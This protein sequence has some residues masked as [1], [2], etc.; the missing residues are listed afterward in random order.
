VARHVTLRGSDHGG[1][2]GIDQNLI[3]CAGAVGTPTLLLRSGIGAPDHLQ[4][5]QIPV[6]HELPG[7]GENL[8]DHPEA[9][10]YYEG[11]DGGRGLSFSTL[12]ANT[13]APFQ[14]LFARRG[15][16]TSNVVEAGGFACTDSSLAEPDVQFH[17]IPTKVRHDGAR[18]TWGRGYYSD[19]CVLKPNSRGRLRLASPDTAEDPIIDL[20]LL[21]TDED[22]QTLLR[23]VKLA[24][25]IMASPEL[26]GTGAVEVAPG[27]N[28]RSDEELMQ[29]IFERLGTSFHPVGT[30]RMGDTRDPLTVVDPDLRVKGLDNV[31]IADASVIPELVAGNTNAP[32]MMIAEVAADKLINGD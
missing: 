6:V 17:F 21:S 2:I 1:R 4:D 30:C 19:A 16:F 18:I 29:Y 12:L 5:M 11:G 23:G 27:P 31:V 25:R 20:N 22:R 28:I 7:V 10:I 9:A 26:S 3:L 13:L 15:L 32:T 24:R 14:Y 8:H